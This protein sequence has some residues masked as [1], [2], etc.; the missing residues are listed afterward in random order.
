MA[1]ARYDSH[2]FAQIYD[3]RWHRYL[4]ET[5]RPVAGV[6]TS[7]EPLRILD[8]ACGT[9]ESI[10]RFLVGVPRGSFFGVDGSEAMLE[11]ARQKFQKEPRV[12]LYR[13]AAESLPFQ[14]GVFD[15]VVCCNSLHYFRNPGKI[16]S[17]MVRVLK[18]EG[19]L[20]LLDWCRDLWHCRFINRWLCLMDRV[21][22]WMYSTEEVSSLAR[23]H[24]IAIESLRR[25]RTSWPV[26]VKVWE[27]MLVLGSVSEKSRS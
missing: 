7:P 8:V 2:H 5:L 20:L 14:D 6:L 9:G 13:A 24:G 4:E 15:W 16:F 25:F 11:V 1:T 12:A 18:P 26:G 10:R 19:H 22:V 3:L 21:H 27:M 23:R 17:E